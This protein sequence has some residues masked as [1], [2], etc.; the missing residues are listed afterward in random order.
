MSIINYNSGTQLHYSHANTNNVVRII[1]S[2]IIINLFLT[3]CAYY[4]YLYHANKHFE[5]GEK[6]L[7]EKPEDAEVKTKRGG[8]SAYKKAIESAGRMLEFYP[9]SRWEE[10]ALLLL[11]KSYYRT[12]QYRKSISK[13]DE[14]F[15]KYPE[16]E[17]LSVAVIWK[18]MSLLRV[19]QPDSARLILSEASN[20]ST[21]PELILL[22]HKALG[23]YYYSEERW[24]TAKKEY[25]FIVDSKYGEEWLKGRAIMKISDCLRR[26]DRKAEALALLEDILSRKPR[27]STKFEAAFQHAKVQYELDNYEDAYDEFKQL[28]RDGTFEKEFLRVELEV[29]RCEVKIGKIDDGRDRLEDMIEEKS[30]GAIAAQA[31]YELG[32]LYWNEPADIAKSHEAF[33]NV[34]SADNKSIFKALADSMISQIEILSDLWQRMGFANQQLAIIDSSQAGLRGILPQDTVYTDTLKTAFKSKSNRR[35]SKKRFQGRDD[36]IQRMVDEARKADRDKELALDSTIVDTTAPLDSAQIVELLVVRKLQQIQVVLEIANHYL[37]IDDFR[38]SSLYFFNIYLSNEL[39][40]EEWGKTISS[41]SYLY[42]MSG[43][44][45]RQK[46]Y[47]ERIIERLSDGKYFNRARQNLGF[48]TLEAEIDTFDVYFKAA[49]SLWLNE[50]NPTAAREVYLNISELADSSSDIR[51]R[52]LYASAYLSRHIFGEDSIAQGYYKLVQD[53]YSGSDLARSARSAINIAH[54]N[55][56]GKSKKNKQSIREDLDQIDELP[57]DLFNDSFED[58]Y[59]SELENK[60]Y[61]AKEVDD[62]PELTT[63]TSTLESLQDTFYPFKARSENLFGEV[64]LQFIVG[65]RGDITGVKVISEEPEEYEF[66]VSAMEVLKQLHYRGGRYRGEPVTVRMK[67][68]FAFNKPK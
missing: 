22:T 3:S 16:S 4:N 42:L 6:E 26:L 21:Y 48:E 13:V 12:H 18:G 7:R 1:S 60:I 63:S 54:V 35:S 34:K 11:A 61:D 50:N 37:F 51:A 31:Y 46:E 24:E 49:E 15:G 5:E 55:Y 52:A 44:S 68:R 39:D 9:D 40:D 25:K 47:D 10:E 45:V 33:S 30:R 67:Q 53:E 32:M 29:A 57:V 23:D 8:S 36:P 64:E 38:D 19:A 65:I 58:D 43:D 59:F 56:T 17:L 20:N 66:G 2:I 14:L 28:L 27:G 62:I 41:I